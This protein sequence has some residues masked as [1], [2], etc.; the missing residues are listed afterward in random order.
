[1]L[2]L[3]FLKLPACVTEGVSIVV[4][5]LKSLIQDQVQKLASLDVSVKYLSLVYIATVYICIRN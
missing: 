4:S 3:F 5:P 2:F 1:M